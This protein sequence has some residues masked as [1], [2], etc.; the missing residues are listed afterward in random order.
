MLQNNGQWHNQ[1]ATSSSSTKVNSVEELDSLNAKVDTLIALMTKTSVDNVPLNELVKSGNVY[2]NYIRN[3]NNNGYG[4]KY[5]IIM[6]ILHHLMCLTSM[7]V[8]IIST[9]RPFIATQKEV[10]KDFISKFEKVEA[11]FDNVER[12][13]KEVTSLKNF[14]QPQRYH[15]DTIKYVQDIIDKSWEALRVMDAM[16]AQTI[17]KIG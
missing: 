15:E 13:T 1:R 7:L 2:V 14:V 8:V 6:P 17:K 4:K 16:E 3:I 9:I 12:L 11:L 5:I 10:S